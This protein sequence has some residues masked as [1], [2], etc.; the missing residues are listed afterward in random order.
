MLFVESQFVLLF[1]PLVFFL[2]EALRKLT[3]QV[4]FLIGASL[5]FYGAWNPWLLILLGGSICLNYAL[6]LH[7][8][9]GRNRPLFVLS[10]LLNLLP[11]AYFKYSGLIASTAGLPFT[12]GFFGETLGKLLPLGISFFT[13]Q[14]IAYLA[15]VHTKKVTPPGFSKY[16]LFISFFPQLIA[17]PIVHHAQFVPQV[18]PGR[19]R[20]TLLITGLFLFTIGFIK[21]TQIADNLAS[22]V[23]PLYAQD[24]HTLASALKATLGYTF[25][26]YFDFSGYSDMALGLAAM[27]GFRLPQ[28]FNS[29]YKSVSITDFWRRWH[30]TLSSWLRDYVYIPLGGNR[31]GPVRT[32]LNL[33]A[34]MLIGGFWHGASW[35]F[36]IWGGLHGLFLALERMWKSVFPGFSLGPLTPI[37]TFIVVAL[38]WVLF[39][40]E[41]FPTAMAVYSGFF[42]PDVPKLDADFLLIALAA[43]LCVFP[44]SNWYADKLEAWADGK[45]FNLDPRRIA[46]RFAVYWSIAFAATV[47]LMAGFYTTQ[48]DRTA[49]RLVASDTGSGV[50]PNDEGDF[51]SNF[52][53][54]SIFKHDT[55]KVFI[56][57]SSFSGGMGT[58][59]FEYDGEIFHSTSVGIGGNGFLNSLRSANALL[60]V[61][62]THTIFISAS[63]LNFG[64]MTAS[65]AF[66]DECVRPLEGVI[67]G[68][69]A[70]RLKDCGSSLLE[71]GEFLGMLAMKPSDP[72]FLQF[73][74]F[75]YRLVHAYDRTAYEVTSIRLEESQLRIGAIANR[76]SVAAATTSEPGDLE[77]GS[78]ARFKWAERQIPESLRPEGEVALALR[79]LKEK[80][81]ARGIRLVAY[82]TPTVAHRDAP[83]IYPRG[84]FERYRRSM[85]TLMSDLG[86]EY[87]DLS[88][89]LPWRNKAMLDFIH[90]LPAFR[91]DMHEV[92]LIETFTDL[93]AI[94]TAKE[95][96][97]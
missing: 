44:N 95:W 59:K 53:S 97:E 63:A 46:S 60:D 61:P 94:E 11:L 36:L 33:M 55:P 62:G 69:E 30:M 87:L 10:I 27:F 8:T 1:L 80:A 84:F 17:G 47:T 92:L 31:H 91:H 52:Y 75:A 82:D 18:R 72:H 25:Q 21:K 70:A 85:E 42:K 89:V 64:K 20:S 22:F 83:H 88:G 9:E 41:N 56:V 81:D 76:L 13:F 6:S 38:L 68:I 40:A 57:G 28:N 71:R 34:T 35:S 2:H 19:E 54:R 73:Q 29:P 39:R 43:A 7:I 48:L 78:D 45:R 50:V 32:Y 24:V 79:Q 15:D 4:W 66:K 12:A 74:N 37:L 3:S 86:I 14:Q 26:L 65:A 93:P 51:R 58:F 67:S 96:Q 90:P 77:N 23:D 49:Y 5:L 16:A